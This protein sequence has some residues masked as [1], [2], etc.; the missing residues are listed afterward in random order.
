MQ[1][2]AC[3]EGR[4]LTV[5]WKDGDVQVIYRQTVPQLSPP[6]ALG[7]IS[8]TSCFFIRNDKGDGVVAGRESDLLTCNHGLA[9][10]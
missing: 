8:S 6:S 1:K 2:L 5:H 7:C 4:R 9:L 10:V 3:C